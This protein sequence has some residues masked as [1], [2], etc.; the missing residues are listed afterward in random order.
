M[1]EGSVI[2]NARTLKRVLDKL[3]WTMEALGESAGLSRQLIS[4]MRRGD[5]VERE[6]LDLVAA[7]AKREYER[8]G[9]VPIPYD[10]FLNTEWDVSTQRLVFLPQPPPRNDNFIRPGSLLRADRQIVDFRGRQEEMDILHDWVKNGANQ[11]TGLITGSAGSGKTRLA[12]EF[13]ENLVSNKWKSGFLSKSIRSDALLDEFSKL[14]HEPKNHFVVVDYLDRMSVPL[15]ELLNCIPA[16]AHPDC[17]VRI[18]ILDRDEEH[19]FK[20][21]DLARDYRDSIH[22]EPE[23]DEALGPVDEDDDGRKEAYQNALRCFAEYLELEAPALNDELDF[24][25]PTFNRILFLHMHALGQL[26]G[27]T[28]DGENG[29]LQH[30]L[31]RETSFWRQRAKNSD[32]PQSLFDY[33][34][35]FLAKVTMSGGA[36]NEREAVNLLDTL[37]VFKDQTLATKLSIAKFFHNLYPGPNWIE[38][39]TPDVLGEHL[40]HKWIDDS[41]FKLE[42][43]EA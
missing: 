9:L 19:F 41:R 8:M 7:A 3:Q 40:K 39:L 1:K 14:L 6:S 27:V 18:L 31:E 43:F 32:I 24:S 34:G 17:R 38:P 21:W 20:E 35:L 2:A 23:V 42:L 16:H 5:S 28:L 13:C 12:L 37:S 25:D 22:S 4:R 26:Q 30:H 11:S 33:F 15:S 29:I 36:K 10:E